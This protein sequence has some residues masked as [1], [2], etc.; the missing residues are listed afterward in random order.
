MGLFSNIHTYLDLQIMYNLGIHV[1][2]ISL[3]RRLSEKRGRMNLEQIAV[4]EPQVNSRV[5]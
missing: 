2:C 4:L 5:K 1:T 3:L